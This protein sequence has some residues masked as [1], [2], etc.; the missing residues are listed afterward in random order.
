MRKPYKIRSKK[1]TRSAWGEVCSLREVGICNDDPST[2]VFAHLSGSKGTATKNHDV[3]GVY[4]CMNCHQAL[5]SGRVSH[6][7]QL[8]A[9]QETQLKLIEKGIIIVE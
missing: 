2:T 6:K 1:I 7:D 3:F 5:D 9:L 8:R 4:A